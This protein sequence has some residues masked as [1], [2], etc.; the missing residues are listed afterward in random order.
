M[1][2]TEVEKL[3]NEK[4]ASFRPNAIVKGTVSEITDK[5]VI[6]DFGYKT[7]GFISKTE[8]KKDIN[9]ISPGMEISAI[10][11]SLELGPNGFVRLSKEKA[12]ALS[13]W[14]NVEKIFEKNL[15]V[16]G[17]IL[18]RVK[19]GFD[20]DIGM[21]AFLPGSQMDNKPIVDYDK[22]LGMQSS[23]K[24]IKIDRKRKNVVLSRRK[25]LDEEREEN[26]KEYLAEL[27]KG[28]ITKGKIRNLTDYGA[29][30]EIE[31]NI[32]GLLHINDMS[33][34]RVNHPSEM[35]NIDNEIEV[36]ITDVNLEK[37]LVAF[38][39]KQRF[40]NPWEE[41]E[42]RYPV[43]SIIEGKVV[44]ITEYGA[45]IQLDNGIEG[46][47]HISE[48][49]WTNKVKHTS[50]I[51]VMGDILK[52]KVIDII[53]A[54]Q[55]ISFSLKQIEPDPWPQIAEKFPVGSI[56]RGK[57][58]HIVDFGAFIEI[59]KG[60]DGFLHI[61]NLSEKQVNHPSEILRKGQK[62]NVIILNIDPDSKKISLGMKQLGDMS[63]SVDEEPESQNNS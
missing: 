5:E 7:E 24:V 2:K 13:N 23:F 35:F 55:K 18:S 34:G 52:L 22:Y 4:I 37:Q 28:T 43:N 30:I 12:D 32:I 57:V 54:E 16:E 63:L 25:L 14:E 8:F 29:F 15:T 9:E 21:N 39:Y 31:H 3:L 60:I 38:G 41:I 1:S 11:E 48:L 62:I 61:S 49:S 51:V 36:L 47:L 33:W 10:V 27:K 45:F 6:I 19:G 59:D 20:V 44:N 26:K 50:E 17:T 46:L 40:P 58:Y 42:T 53:K 56:V